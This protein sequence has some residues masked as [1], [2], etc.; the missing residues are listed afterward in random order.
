MLFGVGTPGSA[1]TTTLSHPAF[2]AV[3][4]TAGT[5][6]LVQNLLCVY[7]PTIGS[8]TTS[9][10]V[11]PS[12][13]SVTIANVTSSFGVLWSVV[14]AGLSLSYV[15]WIRNDSVPNLSEIDPRYTT[16]SPASSGIAELPLALFEAD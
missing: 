9:I 12:G 1:T 3:P 15:A 6:S 10:L 5:Y 14:A 13:T 7:T 2:G 4:V 8:Y 16:S 11:L